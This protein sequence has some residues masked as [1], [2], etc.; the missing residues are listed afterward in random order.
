M[1]HWVKVLLAVITSIVLFSLNYFFNPIQLPSSAN[2][3]LSIAILMLSL[4]FTETLPIAPVALIPLVAFPIAGVLRLDEAILNYIDK[5]IFLFFG[6][7]ILGLALEK[8]N[9]HQ[10]IALGIVKITGTSPN[11]IILG[12][13]IATAF[14]SMWIS[15]TATTMMMYPIALSVNALIE[16]NY[17]GKGKVKNF[18]LVLMLIVA[19]A[20][21]V[22]GITTIVGTPPNMVLVGIMEKEFKLGVD[23]FDWFMVCF[24]MGVVTLG[25]MYFI[26]TF[27][28]YPNKMDKNSI[29]RSLIMGEYARLGKMSRQEWI[30]AIVFIQTCLLWIFRQPLVDF[31]HWAHIPTQFKFK[32]WVFKLDDTAVAI[33]GALLMLCIPS[34]V[35]PGSVDAKK[36]VTAGKSSAMIIGWRDLGKVKWGILLLFGGGLCLAMAMEKSGL[37]QLVG[38]AIAGHAGSGHL[39]MIVLLTISAVFLSELMS[40]VALV[41]VFVPVVGTIAVAMN[42]NPMLYCLPV[43]LGATCAFM[44]PMGTPPNAIV[45]ASKKIKLHQMVTAGF[46]LNILS[47]VFISASCYLLAD[48][49]F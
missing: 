6:G 11:K 18:S 12:F 2:T 23:F 36:G 45:Y 44:L 13:I 40:N 42:V 16:T 3:V 26:L 31:L 17:K 9:L 8:W 27:V 22:G 20:S 19:Y 48:Q 47:S 30:V 49:F 35:R 25:M 29:P 34:G 4:W 5:V 43:T 24:P 37:M 28:L 14:I 7:F 33:W 38:D 21:N 46:F 10:R 41:T 39:L 1:K 32:G 15:N